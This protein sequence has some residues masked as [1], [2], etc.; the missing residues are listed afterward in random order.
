MLLNVFF[1]VL[2]VATVAAAP[3]GGHS[4]DLPHLGGGVYIRQDM[5]LI[6]QAQSM[7]DDEST[8]SDGS[9]LARRAAEMESTQTDPCAKSP[10]FFIRRDV[11]DGVFPRLKSRTGDDVEETSIM[12]EVFIRATHLE[13]DVVSSPSNCILM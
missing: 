11:A 1:A 12:S 7:E 6:E 10:G 3:S 13:R 8:S 4:L 5:P 9:H 2:L